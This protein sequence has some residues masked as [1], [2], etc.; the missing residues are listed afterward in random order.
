MQNI[1]AFHESYLSYHGSI[2]LTFGELEEKPFLRY[3]VNMTTISFLGGKNSGLNNM[4][5]NPLTQD[6]PPP[7]YYMRS[8]ESQSCLCLSCNNFSS[9]S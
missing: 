7:T 8:D 2:L 1:C 9:L 5:C 4:L 3:S 6:L